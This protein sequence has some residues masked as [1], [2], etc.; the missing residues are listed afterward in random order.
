MEDLVLVTGGTGLLGRQ[1]V[2]RLLSDG[3]PVRVVSRRRPPA[4]VP[5]GLTWTTSDLTVGGGL[6]TALSD[7]GVVVHCA[8][9]PRRPVDDVR[10]TERL[11]QAALDA[12]T[13]HLVYLSI[14]GVGRI[15]AALYRA[16][17][18]CERLI[19]SSGLDWTILR[20]TQFH[21]FVRMVF[22]RLARSP[23]VPVPASTD[24]QP[25]DLGVVADRVVELAAGPA[26]G[27]VPELG[28]PEILPVSDMMRVFLRASG[29]R[30]PVLPVHLPGAGAAAFRRGELLTPEHATEG[31]TWGQYLVAR[32]SD[33]AG[34]PAAA[35]R[36][37]AVGGAP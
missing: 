32:R 27:R 4:D 16:K 37:V 17:Y 28:G 31:P 14:V 7:A 11:V 10:A 18:A 35:H 30:R 8:S 21:P 22:D 6:T 5:E 15:P 25:I 9:N 23:V 13:P 20:A 29:R 36:T 12:G 2:T 1:V 26:L 3:R 33:R 34:V 24:C 19:E